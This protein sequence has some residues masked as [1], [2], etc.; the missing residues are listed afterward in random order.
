M[1]IVITLAILTAM[2]A[3]VQAQETPSQED[4]TPAHWIEDLKAGRSEKEAVQAL[5]AAG[6]K[7]VPGL[8]ALLKDPSPKM[9]ALGASTLSNLGAPAKQTVLAL[10]ALLK[11]DK[12][13]E[14]RACA[15]RSLGT[16]SEVSR[17]TIPDLIAALR[18]PS[19]QVRMQAAVSLR[20]FKGEARAAVPALIVY[21]RSIEHELYFGVALQALSE[22]GGGDAEVLVPYYRELLQDKRLASGAAHCL[23]KL[24]GDIGPAKPELIKALAFDIDRSSVVKALAIAGADAEIVLPETKKIASSDHAPTRMI[25]AETLGLL[26]RNSDAALNALLPLFEDERV[27]VIYSALKASEGLGKRGEKIVPVL[28]KLLAYKEPICLW[29]LETVEA[30]GPNVKDLAPDL[31]ALSQN[32]RQSEEVRLEAARVLSSIEGKKDK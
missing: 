4:K 8:L 12:N 30:L 26:A 9:R 7:A 2:T 17:E 24:S 32:P 29:V 3:C 27:L 16:L 14:V 31:K 5:V 23:T 15:A 20:S 11:E 1:K 13:E 22:I 6:P 10:V 28:R 25:A 19:E 21:A 18:D